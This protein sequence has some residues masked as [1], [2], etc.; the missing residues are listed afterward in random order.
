MRSEA[1]SHHWVVSRRCVLFPTASMSGREMEC[2]MVFAGMIA[3]LVT[4]ALSAHAPDSM[5]VDEGMAAEG[6]TAQYLTVPAGVGI[7]DFASRLAAADGLRQWNGGPPISMTA[8]SG[9]RLIKIVSGD[10][11][12]V[13]VTYRPSVNENHVCLINDRYN[14]T[15]PAAY[16]AS[17]WCAARFGIDLRETPPPPII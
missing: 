7:A 16:R 3:L 15:G 14:G 1:D 10:G 9:Y 4:G 12:A 2:V 17:R 13:T 5:P 11:R 6:V 8:P